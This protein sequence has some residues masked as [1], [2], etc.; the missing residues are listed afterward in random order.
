MTQVRVNVEIDEAQVERLVADLGL[1]AREVPRVL[2]RAINKVAVSARTEIVK[3]VVETVNLKTSDVRKRNVPLMKA[4]QR[5]LAALVQVSGR[6]IPLGYFGAKNLS[7]SGRGVSYA[8]TRGQRKTIRQGFQA[9]M[10][11]G[12]AGLFMRKSRLS[13]A[14]E[15]HEKRLREIATGQKKY[16]RYALTGQRRTAMLAKLAREQAAVQAGMARLREESKTA[17][18]VGRLPIAELRG[19][20]VPR[21]VS[22]LAEF[23]GGG[24]EQMLGEKLGRE[25]DNQV[26]VLLEQKARAAGGDEA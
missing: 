15:F 26:R 16:S 25:I 7:K 4:T 23:S 24:F 6:R 12:H 11:S 14:V 17:G 8:I 9:R 20:S 1:F 2:S 21:L 18:L 13:K 10:S 3:R 22:R 19:P 5:T